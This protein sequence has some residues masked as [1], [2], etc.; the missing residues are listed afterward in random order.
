MLIAVNPLRK[1]SGIVLPGRTCIQNNFDY[2]DSFLTIYGVN[3]Y[4]RVLRDGSNDYDPEDLPAFP[5]AVVKG[6]SIS[7]K[8][9]FN[10]FIQV[11]VNVLVK[12]DLL[13]SKK[14][15][16]LSGKE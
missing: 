7:P 1:D 13:N 8:K 12:H 5:E 2:L 11:K 14:I 6:Q 3:Y 10:Y 15:L 9:L 16:N 4:L